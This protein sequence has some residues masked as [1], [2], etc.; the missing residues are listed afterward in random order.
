[1]KTI[2]IVEDDKM[3]LSMYREKFVLEHF[4]VLLAIN[5][6]EGLK[7]AFENKPDLI[8]LDFA[9]P[10]MGG[11][12]MLKQLRVDE[13][14]KTVSVIALTNL[15]V[16]GKII[17]EINLYKPVYCLLKAN[18]TPEDVVKKVNELLESGQ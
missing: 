16:D 4:H 8:L 11:L 9:M 12:E 17:D 6:D 1:M 3:L 15:T 7:M 10:V 14:G 18:T 13:W 5:G 2:L